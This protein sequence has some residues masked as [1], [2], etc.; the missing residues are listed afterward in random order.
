[1]KYKHIIWD[2]NGTI[3]DDAWLCVDIMNKILEKRNLDLIT[4]DDYREHFTFPVR[5]YYVKLG[6]NFDY[7]P[8]EV[9][10]M[11]FIHAFKMRKFEA[12]LYS[13]IGFVLDKCLERNISHSILSAQNQIILDETIA[14]YQIRDKFICVKGLDDD[15]A[16]SKVNIGQTWI[17]TSDYNSDQVIMVGDTVHDYEVAQA[18]GTDCILIASGHNSRDRLEETGVLVLDSPNEII[19]ALWT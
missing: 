12:S 6:F 4:L 9:C 19:E 3:I 8:F 14:Y 17:N 13:Q 16:H 2:W 11:D 18:M 1:M 7:E 15:F 5:D 10:G